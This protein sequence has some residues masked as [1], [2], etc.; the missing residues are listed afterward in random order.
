MVHSHMVARAH[1][2]DNRSAAGMWGRNA[3]MPINA[4]E[5]A[6]HLRICIQK[7]GQCARRGYAIDSIVP[8]EGALSHVSRFVNRAITDTCDVSRRFAYTSPPVDAGSRIASFAS[9]YMALSL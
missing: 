4:D 1:A 8:N 7:A 5:T 2:R 6:Y 3:G 9:R